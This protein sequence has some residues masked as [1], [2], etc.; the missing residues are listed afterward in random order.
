MGS[1]LKRFLLITLL[2]GLCRA[3]SFVP[4][5]EDIPMPEGMISVENPISFDKT[6]GQ[7][8]EVSAS[9]KGTAEQI[10]AYYDKTLPNLGWKQV[11]H[12]EYKRSGQKLKISV[13]NLRDSLIVLFNLVES[14]S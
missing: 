10:S 9:Y 1:A 4:G 8:L 14:N 7:V 2:I 12:L 11:A 13:K 3:A 6:E 5:T